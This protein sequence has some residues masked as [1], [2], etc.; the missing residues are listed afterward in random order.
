[1]H[2]E[3]PLALVDRHLPARQRAVE[4]AGDGRLDGAQQPVDGGR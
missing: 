2:P 4:D 1:M 3:Q